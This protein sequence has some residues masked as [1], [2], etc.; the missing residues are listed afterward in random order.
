M[1]TG[2]NLYNYNRHRVLVLKSDD[3]KIHW[4]AENP[5]YIN[6]VPGIVQKGTLLKNQV[7]YEFTNIIALNGLVLYQITIACRADDD[8]A[9]KAG[10]RVI[11]SIKIDLDTKTI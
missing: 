9:K 1:S 11:K 7:R 10:E 4:H 3:Y 8:T 6:Q 5:V 2:S